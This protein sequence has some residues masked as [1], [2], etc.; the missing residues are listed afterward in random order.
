MPKLEKYTIYLD[1]GTHRNFMFVCVYW[2]PVN[3][4]FYFGYL[5]NNHG[6]SPGLGNI[7][8]TPCNLV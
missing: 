6:V 3:L 8:A 1:K 5:L 4:K 2:S 7:T